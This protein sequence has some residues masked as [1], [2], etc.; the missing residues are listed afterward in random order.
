MKVRPICDHFLVVQTQED[1]D[2][3]AKRIEAEKDRIKEAQKNHKGK[4]RIIK[5]IKEQNLEDEDQWVI[6]HKQDFQTFI[7]DSIGEDCRYVKPGDKVIVR[8]NTR[9]EIT[10]YKDKIYMSFPEKSVSIIIED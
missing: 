2:A 4:P 5:S 7:V 10:K 3:E 9:P 6:E 8:F 1:I